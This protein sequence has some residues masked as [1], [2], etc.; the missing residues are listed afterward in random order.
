MQSAHILSWLHS[1]TFWP[2]VI[3][4]YLALLILCILMKAKLKGIG[5]IK[6]LST[7]PRIKLLDFYFFN[8]SCVLFRSWWNSARKWKK[9]DEK[10]LI[11]SI[12]SHLDN[13]WSKVNQENAE[14]TEK[15]HLDNEI[16]LHTVPRP[17]RMRSLTPH[18]GGTQFNY[19]LHTCP[20][21]TAPRGKTNQSSI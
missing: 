7:H 6:L 10:N 14:C 5:Q 8:P 15:T 20:K 12:N 2:F 21:E 17:N 1:S 19:R 16:L 3:L 13:I 4:A 9:R 18:L 11:H